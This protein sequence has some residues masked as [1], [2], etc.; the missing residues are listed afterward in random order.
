MSDFNQLKR[1]I[2]KF[3]D[4]SLYI[5]DQVNFN[6]R[7]KDQFIR[8]FLGENP[9]YKSETHVTLRQVV[10]HIKSKIWTELADRDKY[11]N[12]RPPA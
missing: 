6:V 7:H 10:T 11:G 8:N 12:S 4:N 2:F 3:G 9:I 1:D 5:G